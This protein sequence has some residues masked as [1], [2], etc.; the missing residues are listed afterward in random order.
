MNAATLRRWLNQ[1]VTYTPSGGTNQFGE[2]IPGV[3][4]EVRAR[5]EERQNLVRTSTGAESLSTSEV[6]LEIEP[7]LDA[8]IDGNGRERPIQARESLV[9]LR[10][11]VVGWRAFL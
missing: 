10:G 9:D 4:V 3:P 8:K 11:R 7:E 2:P 6:L 1:Q 5:F